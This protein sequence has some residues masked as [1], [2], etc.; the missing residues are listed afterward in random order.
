[1]PDDQPPPPPVRLAE[2][3]GLLSLAGEVG[4]AG[5]VT[6]RGARAA[7]IAVYLGD[8]LGL[9]A[10]E[11][12]DAYYLAL[13]RNAGCV[14]DSEVSARVF[15]DEVAMR[16]RILEANAGDRSDVLRIVLAAAF[17][18]T[19]DRSGIS[20]VLA[21]LLSL[22]KLVGVARS[23]C[24]VAQGIAQEFG[25]TPDVVSGLGQVLERWNGQGIPAGLRGEA[26]GRAVRLAE[27]ADVA[28]GMASSGPAAME[29]MLRER[30]GTSLD[31]SLA[32]LAAERA[33]P[34]VRRVDVPSIWA[35]MLASEPK[36]LRMLG[37]VEVDRAVRAMAAF[38]DLQS[39]FT[40]A[41]STRV[42]DLAARAARGM[43]LDELQVSTLTR[44]ALLH[45]IGRPGISVRV[46]DKPGPL[47]DAE[48]ERVR[49]HSYW[50][51][52]ILSRSTSLA[53][54]AAIAS[55][56]HER[57]DGSGYHRGLPNPS[58]PVAG[59]ILA[60]ADAYAAMTEDRAH[61]PALGAD[62]AAAE[63]MRGVHEGRYDGGAADAVLTAAGHHER[64]DTP[65]PGNLTEREV[66]VLR[67]AARGLTN[68]EIG[69]KLGIATKTVG[70]HLQH[71]YEK[72]AVTTRSAATLF[73]IKN[74]LL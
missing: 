54:A 69:V 28:S 4:L 52:R 43:G 65:R 66:D 19:G 10:R 62:E 45:D 67:L 24:E 30:A 44:A 2:L 48:R 6:E 5:T 26:I 27:V 47:T 57:S 15:G 40:R 46:W 53:D 18:G 3:A 22:P 55:L 32:T 37:P 74:D 70:H 9:S 1:M 17:E 50:G 25:V 42:A 61:R 29:F 7:V 72:V 63:I 56:A 51:E 16:A 35:L 38:A 41:H 31:P 39:N 21:T 8:E 23:H 14:A 34:I 20:G 64:R 49:M 68:K 11:R 36:P 73:A 59:R 33:E 58:L 60:V 13:L 12:S 71:V